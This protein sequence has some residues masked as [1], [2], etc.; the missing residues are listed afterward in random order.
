MCLLS[1]S[2]RL[3][4]MTTHEA[5][6]ESDCPLAPRQHLLQ[7]DDSLLISELRKR[8]GT[9][10]FWVNLG[11]ELVHRPES[12]P[13]S[14]VT[15]QHLPGA[16]CLLPL[17]YCWTLVYAPCQAP[18][19]EVPEQQGPFPSQ[20]QWVQNWIFLPDLHLWFR[21]RSQAPNLLS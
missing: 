1:V 16:L 7:G 8:V 13:L 4:V 14:T 5:K 9:P 15:S 2:W 19:C 20:S 11:L 17:C 21:S 10:V 6:Q 3:T 18:N 12:S